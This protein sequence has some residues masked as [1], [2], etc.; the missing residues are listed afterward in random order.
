MT[1]PGVEL[2]VREVCDLLTA[3]AAGAAG[4][5]DGTAA[6]QVRDLTSTARALL[7]LSLRQAAR[8]GSAA[9]WAPTS[10]VQSKRRSAAEDGVS[11]CVR[12]ARAV[13]AGGAAQVRG[14]TVS[15]GLGLLGAFAITEVRSSRPFP[16]LL[17]PFLSFLFGPRQAWVVRLL[18]WRW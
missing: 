12:L 7:P 11:L 4:N 1:L 18:E 10:P 5:A 3:A 2:S 14:N 17:L 6:A 8:I 13:G 9:G 15:H 16:L